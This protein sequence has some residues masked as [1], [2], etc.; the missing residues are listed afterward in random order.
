MKKEI[1]AI[2]GPAASGKSSVAKIVA[3]KIGYLYLDSGAMYRT[4]TLYQIENNLDEQQLIEQLPNIKINFEV[5]GAILLNNVDVTK[6]IREAD[7]CQ[8]VAQ[9]AK[10]KQVREYVNCLLAEFGKEKGIIM[11]GRDIGSVVFKDA[12]VKIYQIASVQARAQRRHQENLE[13]NRESNYEE[14]VAEISAR[15]YEDMH[16]EI[17][18]LTKAVDAI[19]LDTSDLSL[20]ESV[21][22]VLKIFKE[23]VGENND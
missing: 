9:V 15:D 14:I 23:K 16:R 12:K 13:N 7:V 5:G 18:P 6:Q 20:E 8:K 19:E 21:E 11:D 17:A 22:A 10:I 1:I 4:I 3:K 2:D